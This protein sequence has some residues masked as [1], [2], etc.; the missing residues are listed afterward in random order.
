MPRPC[1]S[2]AHRELHLAVGLVRLGVLHRKVRRRRP[3]P[4]RLVAGLRALP[5]VGKVRLMARV[6][7][8]AVAVHRLDRVGGDRDAVVV[9]VDLQH[10]IREHQ[11][12]RAAPRLVVGLAHRHA[13]VAHLERERRLA[14]DLHRIVEPHLDADDLVLAVGVRLVGAPRQ[15]PRRRDHLDPFDHRHVRRPVDLVAG[16]RTDR[17]MV[18]LRGRVVLA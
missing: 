12:V 18:Q 15:Q 2:Q 1:G 7:A 13:G 10:Q 17:G 8:D 16:Q 5:P 14:L 4:V 6:V 11:R 3:R 9:V